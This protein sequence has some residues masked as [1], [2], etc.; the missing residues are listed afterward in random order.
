MH[1]NRGLEGSKTEGNRRL[2]VSWGVLARL[3]GP[4]R[5]LRAFF[6]RHWGEHGR[7]MGQVG[8]KLTT[9]CGQDGP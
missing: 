6:A 8:A 4:W 7:I 2:E 3:G 9:S 5:D 1:Q